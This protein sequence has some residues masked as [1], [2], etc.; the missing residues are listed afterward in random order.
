MDPEA[1]EVA[2]GWVATV[3]ALS[4]MV[5]VTKAAYR[6][7]DP[8]APAGLLPVE[9]ELSAQTGTMTPALKARPV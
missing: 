6:S 8:L 3:G 9:L 7:K 5:T 4:G 1:T 2:V